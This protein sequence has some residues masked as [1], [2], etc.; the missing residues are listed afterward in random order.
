MYKQH[1]RVS[2]EYEFIAEKVKQ[3][4]QTPELS[5]FTNEENYRK[6]K[7]D[8][9]L[10]EKEGNAKSSKNEKLFKSHVDQT[11]QNLPPLRER[12]TS[13]NKNISKSKQFI[14]NSIKTKIKLILRFQNCK[15]F[16]R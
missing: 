5:D 15:T 16:F 6:T 9:M 13:F 3:N 8:C 12:M 14:L 10:S 4:V 2:E 11:E 7:T 1:N